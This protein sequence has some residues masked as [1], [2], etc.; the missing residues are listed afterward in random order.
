MSGK[1]KVNKAHVFARRAQGWSYQRIAEEC[2]VSRITI[3]NCLTR[4]TSRTNK[5][6]ETCNC[7]GC[8]GGVHAPHVNHVVIPAIPA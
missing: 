7:S 5:S 6:R 4:Q 8:S 3:Y 1:P 2:G